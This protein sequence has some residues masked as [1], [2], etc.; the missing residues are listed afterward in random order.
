MSLNLCSSLS[1]RPQ[2][3]S[4]IEKY[5]LEPRITLY[6]KRMWTVFWRRDPID[7][8]LLIDPNTALST[9]SWSPM[10]PKVSA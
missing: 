2:P 3:S 7:V 4:S 10:R 9:V 8:A 5:F 6:P 1:L